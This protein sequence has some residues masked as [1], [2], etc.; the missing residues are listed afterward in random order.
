MWIMG[1][2]PRSA[3]VVSPM[4]AAP[5]PYQNGDDADHAVTRFLLV[6]RPPKFGVRVRAI[7]MLNCGAEARAGARVRPGMV[8]PIAVSSL[9]SEVL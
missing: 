9:S 7:Q 5:E 3:L 6:Q 4:S 2:T 1:P 8:K